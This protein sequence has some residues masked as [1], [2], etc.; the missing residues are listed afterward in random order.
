MYILVAE[1]YSK[2]VVQV[3]ISSLRGILSRS[4]IKV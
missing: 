4:M 1:A 3:K 2:C